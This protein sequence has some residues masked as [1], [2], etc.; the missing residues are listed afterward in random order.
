[1]ANAIIGVGKGDLLPEEYAHYD[2][3]KA[4]DTYARTAVE[5]I[6]WFLTGTEIF[7]GEVDLFQGFQIVLL[8]VVLHGGLADEGAGLVDDVIPP[9]DRS[10]YGSWQPGKQQEIWER[11]N[12]TCSYCGQRGGPLQVDHVEPVSDHWYNQGGHAMTN[13]ERNTWFN[14][15]SN[16]VTACPHCNQSKGSSSLLEFF[17][18]L[19]NR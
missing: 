8:T 6:D 4:W 5:P 1:V 15:S 2:N 9:Y 14:D 10:S 18:R 19:F 12:Y 7:S 13:A 3:S 17:S 16:L 11:D